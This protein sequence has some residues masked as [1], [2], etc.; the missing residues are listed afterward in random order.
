MDAS[1]QGMFYRPLTDQLCQGDIFGCVPLVRLRT[2]P[3]LVK[4]VALNPKRIVHEVDKDFNP[5]NCAAKDRK[6]CR[7]L[8]EC[9]YTH[10][11]LLTHDCE[12]DKGAELTLAIIRPFDATVSEESRTRLR[13]N[14]KFAAFYLP[15]AD[16]WPECYVDFRRLVSVL[17]AVLKDRP[18]LRCLDTVFRDALFFHYF[19]FLTR[20]RIGPAEAP[21][22][23]DAQ[24]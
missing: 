4:S 11:V 19:Q 15:Q 9:D 21:F 17:P 18:R 5:D 13:N 6:S 20:R 22:L 23:P 14:D 16:N 7:I 1:Q 10:A 2:M 8:A 24:N 12:I 3:E